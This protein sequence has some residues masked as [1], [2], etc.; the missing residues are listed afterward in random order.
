MHPHVV[1]RTVKWVALAL[2][3]VAFLACGVAGADPVVP[4]KAPPSQGTV[5]AGGV[6]SLLVK[7]DGT[8]WSWGGNWYGELGLNDTT[9]RF[10][11][12]QVGRASCRERVFRVV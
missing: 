3:V 9:P 8:L 10:V 11:P 2:V 12:T 4:P 7:P 6:D 1:A 5:A